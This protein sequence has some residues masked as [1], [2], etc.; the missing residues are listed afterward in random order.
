MYRAGKY[1]FMEMRSSGNEYL[2]IYDPAEKKL[3]NTDGLTDDFY[4]TEPVK[5][6]YPLPDAGFYFLAQDET[7]TIHRKF[8]RYI[9][10]ICGMPGRY[11]LF[12]IL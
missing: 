1:L 12:L 6:I 11:S 10:M 4:H 5:K 8:I 9:Q 3:C 7:G 2:V